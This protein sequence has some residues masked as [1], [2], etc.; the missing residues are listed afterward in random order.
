MAIDPRNVKRS[1]GGCNRWR[2]IADGGSGCCFIGENAHGLCCIPAG[3]QGCCC[4]CVAPIDEEHAKTGQPSGQR[5]VLFLFPAAAAKDTKLRKKV[6]TKLS[7]LGVEAAQWESWLTVIDDQMREHMFFYEK[8]AQECCYWCCPLGPLQATLF[9]RHGSHSDETPMV[10]SA[11]CP[12]T[13][14]PCVR[15]AAWP[16]PCHTRWRPS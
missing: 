7:E 3:Y 1:G 13:A 8:P 10:I 11:Q 5:S 16:T 6:P 15:S 2:C 12:L 4:C 9:M 14:C